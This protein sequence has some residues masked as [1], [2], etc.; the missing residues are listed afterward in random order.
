MISS[1]F[2]FFAFGI[3]EHD[4]VAVHVFDHFHVVKLM[5]DAIDNIILNFSASSC[6]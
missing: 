6:K 5:N 2:L 4:P 3:M 1:S